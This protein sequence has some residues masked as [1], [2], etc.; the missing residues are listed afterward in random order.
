MA[1][2]TPDDLAPDAAGPV[3]LAEYEALARTRLPEMAYHYIAGGSADEVTLGRTRGCFDAIRLK[4]RVLVDVSRLDTTLDLFGQPFD[5]PILLAP[6]AY[7]RLV[8]PEGELATARGAAAAGVTF[9]VSTFATVD[10]DE[11]AAAA[12]GRLWFQ[13]YVQR[14]RGFTRELV[15]RVEDAGYQALCV[16]V[17]LPCPGTRDRDRRTRFCLPEGVRQPIIEALGA[18]IQRAEAVRED[19]I[20]TPILDPR[21]TWEA[22]DWLRSIARVPVLLKGILAAEDALLAVEH[23][24]S[25]VIVSNHGARNLD[26][27]PAT[28]EALPAVVE[29]VAGRIPVL[30][31]GGIRRGT[32]VLKAL[33][34]GARAVLIGRPY[35]WG[36]AVDGAD[37]VR[38]V[39]DMLRTELKAAMALCGVPTLS[40]IDRR[41]LWPG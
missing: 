10:V 34:L 19:G 37:G 13:L 26:T 25:A 28:I 5:V 14:D 9:V 20:F 3:N 36:L 7:H 15:R 32:D 33:A 11:I 27:T 1:R 31:D 4:P 16:T 23:G 2:H 22:I 40:S 30:F 29:A 38:A 12:A 41:V 39:A 24:A 6:T 8:H 35:L 21:L 18:V 17:D